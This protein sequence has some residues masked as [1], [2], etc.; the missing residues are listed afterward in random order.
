MALTVPL[1]RI[2]NNMPFRA[3]FQALLFILFLLI[4]SPSATAEIYRWTDDQ[5]VVHYSTTPPPQDAGDIQHYPELFSDAD[6][7]KAQ[8]DGAADKKKEEKTDSTPRRAAESP[9]ARKQPEKTDKNTSTDTESANAT[10]SDTLNRLKKN[11][12]RRTSSHQQRKFKR[13]IKALQN[14]Q[15]TPS[16]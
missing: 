12:N 8:K 10:E 4:S 11:L 1:F 3:S 6:K 14:Q 13:R 2:S 7:T 5:G 9:A 15:E 16:E